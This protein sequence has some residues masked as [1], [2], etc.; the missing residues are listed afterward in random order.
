[1]YLETCTQYLQIGL[2][3]RHTYLVKQKSPDNLFAKL[4]A[5]ILHISIGMAAVPK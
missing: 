4:F 1:M 5:Y 3:R 2:I